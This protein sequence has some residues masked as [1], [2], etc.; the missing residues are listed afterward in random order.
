MKLSVKTKRILLSLI[1]FAVVVIFGMEV[2]VVLKFDWAQPLI[3]VALLAGAILWIS[4]VVVAWGWTLVMLVADKHAPVLGVTLCSFVAGVSIVTVDDPDF[5]NGFAH[6]AN[7]VLWFF[8]FVVAMLTFPDGW[9]WCK[10]PT[11]EEESS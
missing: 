4:S 2:V 9:K 3:W 5:L 7:A 8:L 11:I 10:N 6:Y 1:T